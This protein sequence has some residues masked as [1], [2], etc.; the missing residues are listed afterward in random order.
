MGD[1]L[2][3]V[4]PHCWRMVLCSHGGS[5]IGAA[6]NDTTTVRPRTNRVY[7]NERSQSTEMGKHRMLHTLHVLA[8]ISF[9][10]IV[11]IFLL[12]DTSFGVGETFIASFATISFVSTLGGE[13][14]FAVGILALV[15]A[16]SRRQIAW[17]ALF[18]LLLVLLHVLPVLIFRA[19]II[20]RILVYP[21]FLDL[22]AA[23]SGVFG[24][25]WW[26]VLLPALI[27]GAAFIYAG[28]VLAAAQSG[29]AVADLT[30]TSLRS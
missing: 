4:A 6:T 15:V 17:C 19:L 2:Y 8:A 16:A 25:Y 24:R 30:R 14:G 18:A 11:G 12:R 22:Y 5:P 13:L 10:W 26:T 9:I 1:E 20:S 27:P 29:P 28:K 21:N 7:C 23:P 3:A